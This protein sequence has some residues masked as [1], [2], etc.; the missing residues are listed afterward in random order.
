MAQYWLADI[1]G[2]T[3][4]S[5]EGERIAVLGR[6]LSTTDIA[7]NVATIFNSL[8]AS[9]DEIN[10]KC[11]GSSSYKLMTSAAIGAANGTTLASSDTGKIMLLPG[12]E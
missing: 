12:K 11:D 10:N 6:N 4:S 1:P 5:S 3:I 9:V 2:T 7:A 8:G